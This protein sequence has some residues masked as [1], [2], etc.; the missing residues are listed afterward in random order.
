MQDSGNAAKTY[1]KYVYS[2]WS[3]RRD[4]MQAYLTTKICKVNQEEGGFFK[5]I[6]EA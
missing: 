1:V 3:S 4:E 5:L 6:S 2:L